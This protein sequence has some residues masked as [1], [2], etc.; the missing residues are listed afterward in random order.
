MQ[1][2]IKTETVIDYINANNLTKKDFCKQCDISTAVLRKFLRNENVSI[3]SLFKISKAI[4]IPIDALFY[5]TANR[6]C[7]ERSDKAI[8]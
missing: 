2:I 8:Q 1:I 4:K 5:E 6:H 7:E 3:T